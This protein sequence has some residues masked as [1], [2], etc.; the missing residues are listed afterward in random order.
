[1]SVVPSSIRK[2]TV[3]LAAAASC[4][5]VVVPAEASPVRKAHTRSQKVT[6]RRVVTPAQAFARLA[7]RKPERRVSRRPQSWLKKTQ[8][9]PDAPNHDAAIQTTVS[10]ASAPI[11]HAAPALQPL[12]LLVPVQAQLLSHDGFAHRSP[13]APPVA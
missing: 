4:L 12:H 5:L 2:A 8:G 3:A 7:S 11:R 13:R 10:P 1:M 6:H 9:M